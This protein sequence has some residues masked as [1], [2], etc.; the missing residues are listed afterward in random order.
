M[1]E[2]R[3]RRI[4]KRRRR[5][6]L[7]RL[8][9]RVADF[10]ARSR[11]PTAALGVL[12]LSAGV[13]RTPLPES[14]PPLM[15]PCR[16]VDATRGNLFCHIEFSCPVRGKPAAHAYPWVPK[17]PP[18]PENGNFMPTCP[19]ATAA[20]AGGAGAGGEARVG[21][22]GAATPPQGGHAYA[23]T[24]SL[25]AFSDGEDLLIQGIDHAWCANPQSTDRRALPFFPACVTSQ[26]HTHMQKV[27]CRRVQAALA[28]HCSTLK[29]V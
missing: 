5:R 23:N 18:L 17:V 8:P 2:R 26:A 21:G 15:K 20:A 19:D 29:A 28:A 14:A 7:R 3:R 25:C 4:E 6:A 1:E 24:H 12:L 22:I 16:A 10:T 9:L 13:E 27:R 11:R